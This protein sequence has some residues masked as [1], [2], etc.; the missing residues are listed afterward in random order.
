MPGKSV[1]RLTVADNPK[2]RAPPYPGKWSRNNLSGSALS[3]NEYLKEKT[4]EWLEQVK[5][6]EV[7]TKTS[8]SD[9]VKVL[10]L[11]LG[12]SSKKGRLGKVTNQQLKDLVMGAELHLQEQDTG[13]Q[14]GQ[15]LQ[16]ISEEMQEQGRSTA[17]H[18]GNEIALVTIDSEGIEAKDGSV[19]DEEDA[20]SD[21]GDK[22]WTNTRER[23]ERVEKELGVKK[24]LEKSD[25]DIFE[26]D[27]KVEVQVGFNPEYSEKFR[28]R[29]EEYGVKI[30]EAKSDAE[31]FE[32]QEGVNEHVMKTH[33]YNERRKIYTENYFQEHFDGERSQ[34]ILLE[35][36]QTPK[37]VVESPP[38]KER[39][40]HL[41]KKQKS[42]KIVMNSVCETVRTL[43]LNP[44]KEGTLQKKYIGASLASIEFGVPEIGLTARE[45]QEALE[46]KRKL[47]A[48]EEITLKGDTKTA[49]KVFPPEVRTV[50]YSMFKCFLAM[51]NDFWLSVVS[52]TISCQVTAVV[53]QFWNDA[54]TTEPAKHRHPSKA[55]QDGEE[56]VPTRYQVTT[57]EEAYLDFKE[58]CSDKVASIMTKHSAE[59]VAKYSKRV[60]SADKEYRLKYARE[61]LPQKFPGQSWFLEQRP[62]EV[63]MMHD[64][65]T[66]L[67]KV[68]TVNPPQ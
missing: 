20:R 57:N 14:G 3:K 52:I 54:T 45:E 34:D 63:K 61:K 60:D 51:T 50:Y 53:V 1:T 8:L 64:H 29:R 55:V 31:L 65:T 27:V 62:P 7:Y 36:P 16:G 40:I 18:N 12:L 42:E 44:S 48:R 59:L 13:G 24:L 58:S 19:E 4:S 23:K 11:H 41:N 10:V 2:E 35:I 38:F 30:C 46:M 26:S 6:K 47:L 28:A 9:K 5:N 25:V 17:E 33:S 67:C 32:S 43:N 68:S 56:T 49:R 39:L 37:V 66:G 15:E 21:I 22:D